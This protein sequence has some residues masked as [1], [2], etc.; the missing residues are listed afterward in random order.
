MGGTFEVML[1]HLSAVTG[2][3]ATQM[4]QRRLHKSFV[5]TYLVVE[6]FDAILHSLIFVVQRH[7]SSA[8]SKLELAMVTRKEYQ[9][10]DRFISEID[11]IY[12]EDHRKPEKR[13][14]SMPASHRYKI[15]R[16]T[17]PTEPLFGSAGFEVSKRSKGSSRYQTPN[18][19]GMSN[20][21]RKIHFEIEVS[22]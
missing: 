20:A 19:I 13:R 17:L 7:C 6:L 8:C 18:M 10:R 12:N 3:G 9:E 15:T 2:A 16:C 11:C 5:W 14:P 22:A 4:A 21:S 1:Q